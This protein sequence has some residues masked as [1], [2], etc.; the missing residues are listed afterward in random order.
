MP[1]N[2]PQIVTP[3]C[4][5]SLEPTATKIYSIY[6]EGL[7]I[8]DVD[9][10]TVAVPF[11]VLEETYKRLT[12]QSR[13]LDNALLADLNAAG[14]QTYHGSDETGFHMMYLR[15][16]GGYYI[17]VG[18]SRLIGSGAIDVVNAAAVDRFVQAGLRL[19]DGS[20]LPSDIVVLATGF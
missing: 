11:P 4:V 17:D 20:V 16:E 6:S 8:K 12:R 3:Y 19:K 2:G 5:V 10:L 13:A 18:C 1:W 9:L 14:F 15:G 7:S